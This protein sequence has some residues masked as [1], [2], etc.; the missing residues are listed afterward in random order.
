MNEWMDQFV[1]PAC[2]P[3]APFFPFFPPICTPAVFQFGYRVTCKVHLYINFATTYAYILY[4]M[5]DAWRLVLPNW[6]WFTRWRGRA[7]NTFVNTFQPT[8]WS[9]VDKEDYN[10]HSGGRTY[11]QQAR[12]SWDC[13][14]LD[15][16][17]LIHWSSSSGKKVHSCRVILD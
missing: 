16:D 1:D 12:P 10:M 6:S 17:L 9:Y 7:T 15:D 4:P 8:K 13:L 14:S 11:D 2:L 5:G 3:H